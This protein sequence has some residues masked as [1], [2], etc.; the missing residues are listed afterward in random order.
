M[1]ICSGVI[2]LL[3]MPNPIRRQVIQMTFLSLLL[4]QDLQK[5]DKP[6]KQLYVPSSSVQ[7]VGFI[8]KYPSIVMFVCLCVKGLEDLGFLSLFHLVLLQQPSF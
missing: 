2:Q 7:E 4:Q 3:N 6:F 1:H 8:D 5:Q